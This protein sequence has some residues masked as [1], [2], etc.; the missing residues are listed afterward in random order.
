MPELD[1]AVQH[2]LLIPMLAI[3]VN[4]IT[5]IRDVEAEPSRN[6]LIHIHLPSIPSFIVWLGGVSGT[7]MNDLSRGLDSFPNC[8]VLCRRQCVALRSQVFHIINRH[9]TG[10]LFLDDQHEIGLRTE[11]HRVRPLSNIVVPERPQVRDRKPPSGDADLFPH[12][13]KVLLQQSVV[14]VL[15]LKPGMLGV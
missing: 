6:P 11:M 1:Y 15:R 2:S 3:N 13:I 7:D 12:R 4:K 5:R 9:R 10:Y 8:A 14:F